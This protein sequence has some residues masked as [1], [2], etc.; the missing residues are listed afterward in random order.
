MRCVAENPTTTSRASV[1]R[2]CGGELALDLARCR[3]LRRWRELVDFRREHEHRT[4]A[5]KVAGE[6][7]PV[8]I[9][10]PV[11]RVDDQHHSDERLR[12]AT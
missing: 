5:R 8:E 6:E 11:S 9:R 4:A 12:D 7:L 1:Q 10:K 2:K 3:A